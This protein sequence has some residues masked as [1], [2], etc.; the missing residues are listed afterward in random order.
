MDTPLIDE[1]YFLE[2]VGYQYRGI[3]FDG[4]YFYL[5]AQNNVYLF[6][7]SM[8]CLKQISTCQSFT[9]ICYDSCLNC[10]WALSDNDYHA[11][12][13]DCML[14]E[15]DR[16]GLP[17]QYGRPTGISC[18]ENG[19][20]L[21]IAA[22]N[23]IYIIDKTGCMNAHK[24]NNIPDAIFLCV[25]AIEKGYLCSGINNYGNTVRQFTQSGVSSCGILLPEGYITVAM[26]SGRCC[27]ESFLLTVKDNCYFR[28]M[29]CYT[30]S[31]K[32]FDFC[33]KCCTKNCC[34]SCHNPYLGKCSDEFCK[35]CR[36]L[37]DKLC[38]NNPCCSC[39]ESC[40]DDYFEKCC[41]QCFNPCE[42]QCCDP[43]Q[44]ICC[45][46]CMDPCC[47]S[48]CKRDCCTRCK[49]QDLYDVIESIALT[50]TALS[51]ILNAEGEKLQRIL[52]L[53]HDPETLLETNKSIS[54]TI[55]KVTHLEYVLFEKLQI[56]QEMSGCNDKDK[57]KSC[58]P[59]CRKPKC[60]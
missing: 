58:K 37:S 15:I 46:L 11:Y 47:D 4:Q 42:E 56:V 14:R 52:E 29:R 45:E 18:A 30:R 48:P 21:L 50:E 22:D 35:T 57:T 59:R 26:T 33:Q 32:C 54:A 17:C 6:D 53:T 41:R 5:T 49:E 16:I 20:E 10:F 13:L 7:F 44:D 51:H 31:C 27:H 28:I 38:R 40:C 23:N 25:S 43:C 34:E 19:E 55:S 12:R 1:L 60:C 9:S 39:Q 2:R 24:I 8:R 3:T 36:E